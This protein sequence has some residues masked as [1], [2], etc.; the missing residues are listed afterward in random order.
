MKNR[1]LIAFVLL[2]ILSTYT[3]KSNF[4]FQSTLN[5]K[6]I[7]IENNHIL[8][9]E[10][11]KKE[12]S[13]LYKK[14]L[15]FL[16]KSEI[17]DKLSKI[18]FIESYELKKVYPNKIKVKIFEK[19]PVVILKNKK[20]KYY[21][22]ENSTLI[23][24]VYLEKFKSLP[25]VFGDYKNFKILYKS[26]KETNFP[27]SSIKTFHL[28]ETKRWDLITKNGI[29]VKLPIDNYKNSL[30]NFLNINKKPNFKKYEVFDYRI[31]DQLILK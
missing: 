13:F 16:G 17:E 5:V 8:S 9:D 4:I 29:I 11:V 30:K 6:N 2:V 24:F 19:K 15:F 21:F 7:L 28:F 20:K 18:S 3:F 1:F 26:L 31:K 10:E 14:N 22:T 23:N 12:L 25:T 27:L